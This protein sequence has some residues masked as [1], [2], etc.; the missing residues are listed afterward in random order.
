MMIRFTEGRKESL[1]YSMGPQGRVGCLRLLNLK[2]TAFEQPSTER[3][4][5]WSEAFG[6]GGNSVL[7][8]VRGLQRA[9]YPIIF[10]QMQNNS[11]SSAFFFFFKLSRN[12][13]R[14]PKA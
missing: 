8:I 6:A 13:G 4:D 3:T 9:E 12:N 2:G 11:L 10:F 7:R 14:E 1:H 5:L